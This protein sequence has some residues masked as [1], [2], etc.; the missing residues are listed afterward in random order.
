MYRDWT[1]IYEGSHLESRPMASA[2]YTIHTCLLFDLNLFRLGTE[3]CQSRGCHARSITPF[4]ASNDSKLA[5]VRRVDKCYPMR[6]EYS[7]G[8]A[9]PKTGTERRKTV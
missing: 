3:K 4:C 8:S 7:N 2:F 6:V 5:R 9:Q 1:V